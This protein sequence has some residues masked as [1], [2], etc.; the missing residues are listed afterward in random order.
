M[1]Q[2]AICPIVVLG[3]LPSCGEDGASVA[4]TKLKMSPRWCGAGSTGARSSRTRSRQ[5]AVALA[6][7]GLILSL[8]QDRQVLYS[9]RLCQLMWL[10][11]SHPN[12]WHW[13]SATAPCPGQENSNAHMAI[14]C[15]N[16][17]VLPCAQV[18]GCPA[19]EMPACLLAAPLK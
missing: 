8:L 11:L 2:C 3:A 15:H 7:V 18:A 19:T 1:P 6:M 4:L 13:G 17:H 9:G 12:S 5:R 14:W 10:L 16:G